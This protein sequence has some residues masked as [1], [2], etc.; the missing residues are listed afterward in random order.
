[1]HLSAADARRQMRVN[2]RCSFGPLGDVQVES[3]TYAAYCF[4]PEVAATGLACSENTTVTCV[5]P[6]SANA[7]VVNV[8]VSINGNDVVGGP[9]FVPVAYPDTAQGAYTYYIAPVASQLIPPGGPV[10]GMTSVTVKGQGFAGLGTDIRMLACAFT[11]VP[12]IAISVQP[13]GRQ[14]V[15]NTSA[16]APSDRRMQVSLNLQDFDEVAD[17]T[18]YARP[19]FAAIVPTGGPTLPAYTVTLRG[20][21]FDGMSAVTMPFTPLCQFGNRVGAVVSQTEERNPQGVLESLTV[22]VV[23]T[24][25]HGTPGPAT[26]RLAING[27]DFDD[28][29]TDNPAAYTALTGREPEPTRYLYYRQQLDTLVPVGGPTEGGTSITVVGGGFQAFD[30]QASSAR[31]KFDYGGVIT[32]GPVTAIE[33]NTQLACTVP[34]ARFGGETYVMVALNGLHFVGADDTAS[35]SAAT[36]AGESAAT[37]ADESVT[38]AAA[39]DVATIR[40]IVDGGTTGLSFL[41]YRNPE[42]YSMVPLSGPTLGSGAVGMSQA[43]FVVTLHGRGFDRLAERSSAPSRCRYGGVASDAAI[44]SSTY[45]LCLLPPGEPGLALVEFSVNGQDYIS[46]RDLFIFS[47]RN[48]TNSTPGGILKLSTKDT[49]FRESLVEF[50]DHLINVTYVDMPTPD[51]QEGDSFELTSVSALGESIARVRALVTSNVTSEYRAVYNG[52]HFYFTYYSQEIHAVSPTGG[53]AFFPAVSTASKSSSSTVSD[54]LTI[55][56]SGI[57]ITPADDDATSAAILSDAANATVTLFG[58][59]F[60]SLLRPAERGVGVA[61][62]GGVGVARCKFGLTEVPVVA[63]E[64]TFAGGRGVGSAGRLTTVKCVAPPI[65][66]LGEH[67]GAVEVLLALNGMHFVSALPPITYT[68]YAQRVT[69]VHPSGGPVGGGTLVT[70]SGYGLDA[71]SDGG[72][73]LRCRFGSLSVRV[74]LQTIGSNRSDG[75]GGGG[76]LFEVRCRSPPRHPYVAG[77]SAFSLSLNAYH[78]LPTPGGFFTY[79]DDPHVLGIVPTGGPVLGGTIVTVLGHGFD[80]LN[81]DI[82]NAV[83]KFGELGE[84]G[85][86]LSISA[87][88]TSLT[89]RSPKPRLEDLGCIMPPRHVRWQWCQ[90]STARGC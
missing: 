61:D 58:T 59:G 22:C 77:T 35:E 30:G 36:A 6:A 27:Q 72:A 83:C 44:V 17:F 1:M 65:D 23:P 42:I 2:I 41:Y 48:L 69:S 3:V 87:D 40:G 26:V 64:P 12:G 47:A 88:G 75:A 25:M 24:P 85:R 71:M 4:R 60:D 9:H 81:R 57:Q 46:Q 13:D 11:G 53:P 33:S 62:A 28:G 32:V 54:G 70:L 84:Y 39:T 7:K 82:N 21:R 43:T 19:Q 31:C 80:G 18:F 16:T 10:L 50:P 5:V 51:K 8:G 37:A 90:R 38:D 73:S 52:T 55:Q 14:M 34:F 45:A 76:G 29:M 67:S 66:L 49:A 20:T 63:I 56:A 15:C 79:Y 74:E 89:C 68:Y 86:V 78:Y